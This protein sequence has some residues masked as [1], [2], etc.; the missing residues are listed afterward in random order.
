MFFGLSTID[1]GGK[2][3]R[4]SQPV[5]SCSN[6]TGNHTSLVAAVFV[7]GVHVYIAKCTK[8]T[9]FGGFRTRNFFIAP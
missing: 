3:G 1:L 5:L 8:T 2:G 4:A 6:P 7:Y 9:T